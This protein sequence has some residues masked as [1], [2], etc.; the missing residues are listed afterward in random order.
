[1]YILAKNMSLM[2]LFQV[3]LV[4]NQTGLPDTLMTPHE[5]YGDM[6]C[7]SSVSFLFVFFLFNNGLLGYDRLPLDGILS[8]CE[9]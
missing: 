6:L 3:R 8:L 1:M 4:I 5:L 7:F 2:S 9:T